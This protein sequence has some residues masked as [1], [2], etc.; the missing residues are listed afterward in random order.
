MTACCRCPEPHDN[1]PSNDGGLL[2]Q[3]CWE[4]ESSASWWAMVRAFD[5]AGLPDQEEEVLANA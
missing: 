2:C 1:W 3:D 4:T 5:E